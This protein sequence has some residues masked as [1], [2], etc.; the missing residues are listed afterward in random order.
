MFRAACRN[1]LDANDDE[2]I[3]Y[4]AQIH[5]LV[6]RRLFA[7]NL[8]TLCSE[9][10]FAGSGAFMS[11]QPHSK[12]DPFQDEVTTRYTFPPAEAR[13]L[14]SSP[15]ERPLDGWRPRRERSISQVFA[16]PRDTDVPAPA[17][18]IEFVPLHILRQVVAEYA[19]FLG[20]AAKPVIVAEIVS[21]HF[22]PERFPVALLPQLAGRLLRRL[23]T[24]RAA[25]DFVARLRPIHPAFATLSP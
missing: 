5:E 14:M 17:P 1:E 23:D 22:G 9:E 18:V 13:T 6:T 19:E 4:L 24:S 7:G 15:E 2:L 12:H 8:A 11:S 20:P 3:D 25:S 10:Q 16:V 21:L